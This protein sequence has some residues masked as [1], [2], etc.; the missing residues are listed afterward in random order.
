MLCAAPVVREAV[1]KRNQ[2]LSALLTLLVLMLTA[3]NRV[4]AQ[5]TA[6]LSGVVKDQQGGSIREAKVTL[7]SKST[8]AERTSVSNDEGRYGFVSLVP[9]K[10]QITVDAGT[11]FSVFEQDGL[12]ITVGQEAEFDPVLN[13]RGVATTT[14]VTAETTLIEENKTEVSNTVD[15]RRIDNLPINGRDYKNFTLTDS[16]TTRD[17]SP[18]IGP[19]PNSGLNIG[20]ARARSNM[21]SVDGADAVDNSVNGIRATVSQEAVQE[22]QLVLSNYNAEYGRATGGV[23]N[24]VTKSG[25]NELHGDAFV[26]GRNKSFQAR[27]PFSGQIDPTSGELVPVKQPYTR[28]QTGLTLGGP[29]KKDKTFFFGSYEYTQREE[30]GF[31]SIGIDNFGMAPFNCGGCGLDGLMLT[32]DQSAAVLQLLA[33]TPQQ[34]ALAQGYAVLMG[35]A[36]SVALNRLD[37]GQV[38]AGLTSGFLTPGPGAQFPIPVACPKGQTMNDSAGTG[39]APVC[40]AAGVY[41]APLPASYV[42]L[43]SIRGNYPIQEKTSLWSLKLDQNWNASNHSFIRVGV[44]PSLVTGLPSTSQNQVFGQNSGSRAGYNQSRDLNVTFQHDTVTSD[45][46]VNQFRFQFA[47]RGLHFGFSQLP[48]GSDIGVNIPGFAYFGREPYSTVDRIER[49]YE[50]TDTIAKTF[51]RHTLKFGVDFNLIQLRSAKAQIF[52]LDFGGDVNFGGI[53]ASNFSIAFTRLP[54]ATG[55]QAYGLGIPTTYIQGIGNSNQPF[56]NLPIGFFAQDSWKVNRRLTLNYGIRYDVEISPLFAPATSVNAAAEKALGVVEGIPRDYNN[57]APRFG[58]AWDPSGSGKTSIRLGYG[59]FYD[60]PLLAIAF[61]SVTADGGRSVQLLSAGGKPSACGLVTPDCATFGSTGTDSPANLNGSSIF[62]GVLN[63]GSA[64]LAFSPLSL[65]YLPTQQ[66]FDPLAPNSLFANQNY[67]TAGFPLPILPFTLPVAANFKYGYAQQGN[68]T[69][70][71]AF[72]N[73][74]KVSVG[75][76]YTRGI[77][78]NRPV[79]INSTDPQLLSQNAFN[80]AVSGLGVSNPVTVVVPSGAANSCV[81]QGSGSIFLIAPG[82]LGQGFAAPNCNAAAAVGFVGTPAY[83]NFFRPSGP[84]PSFA[85]ATPGGYGTQVALAHLAGYPTGFGVP[86]PFN[87]VDAQL[88]D[89]SSW[90]N[91]LTINMQKRFSHGFELLSSY[92]WSHSIDTGT[93]LQSTLEPQDSRFPNL[94]RAN[95]VNDQRHRWVTSAVFMTGAPKSGDSAW[96]HFLGG[97]TFAPLIEVS[98]GRPFNVITGTDTR[99]DLGA[100]EARPS[101]VSSGTSSPFIP[102]VQFGVA[103]VCLTNAGTPFTVPFFTPPA[104]CNGSLGRNAFTGPGFFQIDMRLSKTIPLGERWSVD[105][106]ADGFNM[107]NR[108]NIAAVNQ[109]CD[110]TVGAVCLS[111]QPTAAYDARQFQ[112]ALKLHW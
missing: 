79:D 68:L 5:N 105:L 13:L 73:S 3:G 32:P 75:Y 63:T 55:L 85:A 49:R 47:R 82:A 29:I 38:A 48:G 112:F 43:N 35:S 11:N 62:Q 65:A 26:F 28:I 54:G 9:G 45:S 7:T 56:D 40:S 41:V 93:D 86:V 18:T 107:L 15:Q 84:N 59:L 50:F 39:T 108:T 83:F 109:L 44:S 33:G 10:Y 21:V 12:T 16:R 34:Q 24:I 74:W 14:T 98:S 76:Q 1:M 30:T 52:E 81:N 58:L 87:S 103:D 106:I 27:N 37:F 22:F 46:A 102:G 96:R 80:A 101:V 69:I 88:S 19:A 104:G 92:T 57:F 100:S 71:R 64:D 61:N 97:F 95:S 23:I 91:A 90:Y 99:L 60:H 78:L 4:V 42:G 25:G 111:G 94:E 89:A 51:G 6:T 72:S 2:M 67:L 36:S 17:V 66:R 110:P 77:H 20:G 31:S 8:G 53:D 70:E